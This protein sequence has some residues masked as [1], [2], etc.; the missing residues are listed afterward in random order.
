MRRD[1]IVLQ[2]KSM[3]EVWRKWHESNVDGGHPGIRSTEI[4]IKQAYYYYGDLRAWL[5][6]RKL[7]CPHCQSLV[8]PSLA[9]PPPA[10]ISSARPYYRVVID[11][12][13]VGHTDALTGATYD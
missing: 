10:T 6:A 1:K 8:L 9:K 7:K 2:A 12:T 4:C 5:V 3:E 11:H 13:A